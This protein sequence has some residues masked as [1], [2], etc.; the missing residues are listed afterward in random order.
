MYYSDDDADMT[1]DTMDNGA[2]SYMEKN[3]QES[4]HYVNQ[5]YCSQA[6]VSAPG[7]ASI[8]TNNNDN[9]SQLDTTEKIA[10][11]GL[12]IASVLGVGSLAAF[13]Y[14]MVTMQSILAGKTAVSTV[15][16]VSV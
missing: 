7:T 16:I 6:G 1:F 5:L 8:N 15:E 4:Q 3:G 9:N 10:I 2:C 13:A 11:A 12:V 14:I